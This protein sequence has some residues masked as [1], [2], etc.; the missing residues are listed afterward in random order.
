MS[1]QESQEKKLEKSQW[2]IATSLERE[3]FCKGEKRGLLQR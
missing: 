1:P 3:D 2:S